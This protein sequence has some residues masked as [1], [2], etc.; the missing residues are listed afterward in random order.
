MK[1]IACLSLL[2]WLAACSTVPVSTDTASIPPAA[3]ETAPTEEVTT[4]FSAPI[5]PV[6][7]PEMSNN[8]AVLALLD[9]AY[10]EQET[11]HQAAAGAA[12]ERALRIEPRNPWLWQQL[13]QIRLEEGQYAQAVTLAKKSNSLSAKQPRVQVDNWQVIARARVALGDTPGA[14]EAAQRAKDLAHKIAD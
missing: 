3:E 5:E 7:R 4:E 6:T 13:A 12:L 2:L 8:R 1:R 9:Q 10:T 11:G 14:E